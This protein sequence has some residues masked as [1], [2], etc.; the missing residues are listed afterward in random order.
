MGNLSAFSRPQKLIDRVKAALADAHAAARTFFEGDSAK[1][2]IEHDPEPGFKVRKLVFTS[3]LPDV[4]EG[5]LTD[6]MNNTRNAFDQAIFAACA[7]IDKPRKDTHYPWADSETDLTDWRLRNKKS[8][9]ETIPKELWD[10][11]ISHDPYPRKEAN[12]RGDTG[13]R[14][15]ATL[16]N[17]KHTVGIELYAMVTSMK[18]GTAFLSGTAEVRIPVWNPIKNEIILYRWNGPDAQFGGVERFTFDVVFDATA[19]Q[20]LQGLPAIPCMHAFIEQAQVVCDTLKA[21][22]A[23]LGAD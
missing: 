15:M 13:I 21:R 12:G 19:P 18:T 22:A 8:G 23:E 16:A 5:R 11:L 1:V 14:A 9:K 6:A 4:V 2:I 20:P 7:A 10:V 3:G 17:R